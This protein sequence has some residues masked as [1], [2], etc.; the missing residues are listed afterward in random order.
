MPEF[1]VYTTGGGF[2][3]WD[4][5]N[6]LAMFSSGSQIRDMM[7]AG[8]AGGIIYLVLKILITGNM[9]G[10]L[11]Y[12][13]VMMAISGLSIGTKA[14]VIVMDTTYPLEIYGTVDNVPFSVAFV[15]NVTSSVSYSLTRRMETLLAAP[16]DLTYQRHGMLFGASILSQASRW[17]ALTPSFESNIANFME[18]CV[19]DGVGTGLMSL[20]ALTRSG[21][22]VAYIDANVPASLAFYNIQDD[23]YE[24]CSEGWPGLRDQLAG[25]VAKVLNQQANAR[26][27]QGGVSAGTADLA[28]LTG[29]M[30]AFQVHMG[31]T[32]YSATSY[33]Q[34]SMMVMGL[35]DG[36]SRLISSSGNGAA[37]DLYQASR[38]EQQTNASYNAIASQATKWVPMLK[39]VFEVIYIGAF[40]L[41]LL[42]MMTPLGPS[43]V[44][45]YFSGFVWLA[46]WEPLTAILHT[47]ITKS[48]SGYYREHTTTMSDVTPEQLLT[49]ANHVGVQSVEQSVGAAA[50]IPM[51]MIPM[52]I[53]PIFFGAG[54]MGSLATSMLNVGQG[55]A[56]ETGREA[57]TGNISHGNVSMHNMTANKW[58]QSG[59]MDMGRETK[60]MASGA[61][62]THH[63]DGTNSISQGT[64]L[65]SHGMRG[66]LSNSVRQEVSERLGDSVRAT[67]AQTT[68]F[69]RAISATAEQISD[70]AKTASGSNAAGFENSAG[71]GVDSSRAASKLY[72]FAERAAKT[73]GVSTDV[74]LQAMAAGNLGIGADKIVKASAGLAASGQIKADEVEGFQKIAEA[75]RNGEYREQYNSLYS[76]LDRSFSSTSGTQGENAANTW[77]ANNGQ[78]ATSAARLNEAYE[79]AEYW[80]SVQSSLREKGA[81]ILSDIGTPLRRKIQ[82]EENLSDV[83]MDRIVNAKDGA[84]LAQQ[85]DLVDKY[86]P[87]VLA[88]AGYTPP[89][90]YVAPTNNVGDS[91]SPVDKAKLNIDSARRNGAAPEDVGNYSDL[92]KDANARYNHQV[93]TNAAGLNDGRKKY[94]EQVQGH[95]SSVGYELNKGARV[96][97]GERA[98]DEFKNAGVSL[99]KMIWGNEGKVDE[100]GWYQSDRISY[101]IGTDTIRDEPPAPAIMKDLDLAVDRMGEDYGFVVT[102]AAQ[103]SDGV[104][105]V[106]RIG[107]IRHDHEVGAVD[108]YLTRKG[109]RL[110]PSQDPEAY[111]ELIGYAAQSFTGIGHYSWGVHIGNGTPAFWGPDTTSA[112]ADPNFKAAYEQGRKKSG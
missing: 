50:A 49:W 44:R 79:T 18:N 110:Y 63:S 68:E 36:V 55:A 72:S 5:F 24:S 47:T 51:M 52:L 77:R 48:A 101:S 22:L 102:S 53:I 7:A 105:G 76:A 17:R 86:L 10:T 38:A 11:Q 81:G 92:A 88:E 14:R 91:P 31:L 21:D 56:I 107:K 109:Q 62:V 45:G 75:T 111:E 39:I 95:D 87:Q 70:Y 16:D 27:P 42:L 103:P 20:D 57:A 73:H 60:V 1:E 99:A 41:A 2:F 43:V 37:M 112:T 84:A 106:D 59:L 61:S 67:Q 66:T 26:A 83:Q 74:A 30:E 90:N 29:S 54:R 71:I 104:E 64:A 46:G 19:I 15:A 4:T 80:E 85:Q 28:G 33:L 23:E 97:F 32:G 35:G 65:D 3:L 69:G 93:D 100:E 98:I 12:M 108:G 58:N 96:K 9:Q 8:A 89:N 94:N 13:L 82:S 40:P 6:F 34:Q 78:S 25:E